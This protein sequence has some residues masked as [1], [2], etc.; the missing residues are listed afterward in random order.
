MS[1][2][3]RKQDFDR[4]KKAKWWFDFWGNNSWIPFSSYFQKKEKEKLDSVFVT[5]W[6]HNEP[7]YNECPFFLRNCPDSEEKNY[8]FRYLVEK[9]DT[10]EKF[11]EIWNFNQDLF[12]DEQKNVLLKKID[13]ISES[14]LEFLGKGDFDQYVEFLNDN[15]KHFPNHKKAYAIGMLK[16][17][18][19]RSSVPKKVAIL[20]KTWSSLAREIG[21]D[22]WI[23]IWESDKTTQENGQ[24]LL[25]KISESSKKSKELLYWDLCRIKLIDEED[26]FPNVFDLV[27]NSAPG[28]LKRNPKILEGMLT[29]SLFYH[30]TYSELLNLLE[31][32]GFDENEYDFQR[33]LYLLAQSLEN[34]KIDREKTNLLLKRYPYP[35]IQ[36]ALCGG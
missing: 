33:C 18:I 9:L 15:L 24:L 13:K 21:L 30:E 2:K 36:D 12:N 23:E 31:E 17:R 14:Y 10:F 4:L 8:I 28:F 11:Y 1:K 3:T 29:R 7:S 35:Q 6:D 26:S 34:K 27:K 22:Y 25:D 20:E 5:V 32:E 16:S 19:K